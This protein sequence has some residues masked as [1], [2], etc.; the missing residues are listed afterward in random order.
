MTAGKAV[1]A[2]GH[3]VVATLAKREYDAIV[4]RN[5][6][7]AGEQVGALLGTAALQLLGHVVIELAADWADSE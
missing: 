1:R 4:E 5:D 6:L 2:I 3:P 7:T